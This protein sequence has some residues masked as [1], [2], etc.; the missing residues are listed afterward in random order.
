M[1][2]GI[3]V[4]GP[5]IIDSGY[6]LKIIKQLET[7]GEL[8]IC[9]GG[10]MGR[11]AV[12]DAKLENI[13]DIKTKRIPSKSID[14]LYKEDKCEL[15]FLLNSGKSTLTGHTFGYKVF[16]RSCMPPVIQIERPDH[17]DGC[18]IPW[19]ESTYD[20]AKELSK[21]MNLKL[22]TPDEVKTIL[23]TN[24]II[25]EGDIIKRKIAG[26]SPNENIFLNGIVIGKSI[27]N[28]VTLIAKDDMIIDIE[29]GQ[30]KE[31]GIE[32]LGKI[33]ISKCVIKTGLL[34]RSKITKP[35]IIK[36]ESKNNNLNAA[37][38][39][40]A[41]ED[42]YK[43]KNIDIIVTVGDDTTLVSSDILYRF[44][45]PIIGITDGDLDKVVED[46][47]KNKDSLIIEF[48]SGWDDKIGDKIFNEIFKNKEIIPINNIQEFKDDIIN[49]I[50]KTNTQYKI[51]K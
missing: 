8:N 28:D 23:N 40:H 42:V 41:A 14:K 19:I 33:D 25:H 49:L 21:I 16:N 13:I 48:E 38:L 5:Q 44:D 50:N 47:F 26:V 24:P 46:G 51:K 11:T 3:V 10:T 36:Q 43:F 35:R 7:Y 30:I 6:A 20:F 32:K 27:S 15:I 29:G 2:I 17:E 12:I 45:V 1:K 34:R 4:H 9:L 18:I 31:H 22:V 37:F 39:N